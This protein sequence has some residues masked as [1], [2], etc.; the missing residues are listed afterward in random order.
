MV[1]VGFAE[2]AKLLGSSDSQQ[3][4][5]AK[6]LPK[7]VRELVLAIRLVGER[8]HFLV[9]EGGYSL[10]ELLQKVSAVLESRR[11]S[12]SPLPAPR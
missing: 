9:G 2:P 7:L 12:S 4:H 1:Q 10:A 11:S 6:L 5:L 8:G 3:A